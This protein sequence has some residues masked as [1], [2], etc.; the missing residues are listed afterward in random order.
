MF[1]EF[2]ITPYVI[3]EFLYAGFKF[4]TDKPSQMTDFQ[5]QKE[6]FIQ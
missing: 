3:D 5:A 4:M 1:Q 6:A 2:T